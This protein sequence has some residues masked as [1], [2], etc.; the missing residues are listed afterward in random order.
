MGRLYECSK[1][2]EGVP[3]RYLEEQ[4]APRFARDGCTV[5]GLDVGPSRSRRPQE[6]TN[7]VMLKCITTR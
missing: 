1:S 7:R 2:G 6:G 4:D 5:K 3:L